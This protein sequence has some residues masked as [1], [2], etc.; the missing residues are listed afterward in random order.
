MSNQR[1]G[2]SRKHPGGQKWVLGLAGWMGVMQRWGGKG[3][4]QLP[5][6]T[7]GRL[8]SVP[9]V[10]AASSVTA[11]VPRSHPCV[12]KGLLGTWSSITSA[13]A[14]NFLAS[15]FYAITSSR[16]QHLRIYTMTSFFFFFGLFSVVRV[17]SHLSLT[18]PYLFH[19]L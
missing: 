11:T 1:V 15:P 3:R 9:L 19:V 14:L 4:S 13:C 5:R 17:L 2:V 7:L 16:S 12:A 8:R 10:Q 6:T 18:F